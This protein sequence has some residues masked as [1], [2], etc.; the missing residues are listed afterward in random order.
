MSVVY[1]CHIT[2]TIHNL[3]GG[4]LLPLSRIVTG[5]SGPNF[6]ADARQLWGVLCGP[7]YH[8]NFRVEVDSEFS[9][10]PSEVN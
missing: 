4:N 10:Q 6:A 9:Y 5:V 8:Q 1:G 7:S 2:R 3:G